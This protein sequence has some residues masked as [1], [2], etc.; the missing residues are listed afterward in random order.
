MINPKS[1]YKAKKAQSQMQK[2]LEQIFASEEKRGIK[3]VVR[4]DR[5]IERIEI[6]GEEQKELKDL[7]NSAMKEAE[8]K[9]EK[10][11]RSSLDVDDLKEMLSGF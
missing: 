10:Q 4:G 2:Q 5:K 11:L 1:I 6:D 8:K 7:I 3:V 9:V